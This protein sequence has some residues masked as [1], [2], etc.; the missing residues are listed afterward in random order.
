MRPLIPTDHSPPT[1]PSREN[2]D[3]LF[4]VRERKK[5][6]KILNIEASIFSKVK[7]IYSIHILSG[8]ELS[9]RGSTFSPALK[10]SRS[11]TFK[12]YTRFIRLTQ[13][14]FRYVIRVTGYLIRVTSPRVLSGCTVA[15]FRAYCT[16]QHSPAIKI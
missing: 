15:H 10:Y 11:E 5:G 12:E 4:S 8:S 2:K 9:I 1:I 14:V 13:K 7:I 3:S 16:G 6:C